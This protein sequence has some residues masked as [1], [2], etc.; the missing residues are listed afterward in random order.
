MK[1]AE[2]QLLF[3]LEILKG[4]LRIADNANIFGFNGEQRE[5]MYNEIFNQQSDELKDIKE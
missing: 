3:L 2:K 4:S 1:I 5:N